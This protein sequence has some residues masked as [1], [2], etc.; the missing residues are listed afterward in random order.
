VTFRFSM[1]PAVE[2]KPMGQSTGLFKVIRHKSEEDNA[3]ARTYP[4][5]ASSA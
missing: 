1:G 5:R 2:Y 4:G 3:M